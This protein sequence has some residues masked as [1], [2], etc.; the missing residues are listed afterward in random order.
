MAVARCKRKKL[1]ILKRESLRV[2]L[3]L[4]ASSLDTFSRLL[5]MGIWLTLYSPL[6]WSSHEHDDETFFPWTGHLLLSYLLD[7][8]TYGLTCDAFT[9]EY[10]PTLL[11]PYHVK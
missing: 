1:S 9:V 10:L 4:E 2:S 8:G 3:A 5:A 11:T 6:P 7:D